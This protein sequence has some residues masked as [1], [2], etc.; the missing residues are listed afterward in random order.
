[1]NVLDFVRNF[2][3]LL[4]RFRLTLRKAIGKQEKL[5]NFV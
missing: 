2:N 1:M 3:G 4:F 5:T